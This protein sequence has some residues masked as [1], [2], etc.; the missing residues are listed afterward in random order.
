L[1]F[2]GGEQMYVPP[3]A[4]ANHLHDVL[5]A[6]DQMVQQGGKGEA[7]L[8][9]AIDRVAELAG[10]RRSLVLLV[11][12]LFDHEVEKVIAGLKRLRVQRHDVAV[13]QLLDD[14]ERDLPFEGLTLF[15]SL[16]D[17]RRLLA[18][19]RSIRS[20]YLDELN[21]FLGRVRQGCRESDVG[22]VLV[23]TRQPL[24]RTLLD[25]VSTRGRR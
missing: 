25:L 18:D 16:E 21:G 2:G 17:D 1:A 4:R 8:P 22:H 15:E 12:D 13:V 11:S 24:E 5:G 6:I 20:M 10:H 19:P 7:G 14:D 3:R 9:A 23:S